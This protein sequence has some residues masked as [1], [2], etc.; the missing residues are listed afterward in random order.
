MGSNGTPKK[1]GLYHYLYKQ[2]K[3]TKSGREIHAKEVERQ[4]ALPV[5]PREPKGS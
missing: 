1:R 5:K 2:W 4:R 3:E